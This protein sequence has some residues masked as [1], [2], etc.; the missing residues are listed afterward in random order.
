MQLLMNLIVCYKQICE[1]FFRITNK[2]L[3]GGFMAAIDKYTPK[4]MTL[5]RARRGAFGHDM[6][7]FLKILD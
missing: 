1:E 7:E 4:L 6:D 5:Y 2:D 3:L